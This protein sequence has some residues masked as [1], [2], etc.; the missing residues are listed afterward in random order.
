ML[1]RLLVYVCWWTQFGGFGVL[2]VLG[3]N[4]ACDLDVLPFGLTGLFCYLM[5]SV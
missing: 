3:V 4:S 5:V 1:L 2:S